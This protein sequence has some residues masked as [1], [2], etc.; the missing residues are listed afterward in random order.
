MPPLR[1]RTAP[2][3]ADGNDHVPRDTIGSDRRIQDARVTQWVNRIHAE[4]WR[5]LTRADRRPEFTGSE[6]G[7]LGRQNY[8]GPVRPS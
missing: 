4:A 5:E 2:E 6:R 3:L 7:S 8:T 1:V